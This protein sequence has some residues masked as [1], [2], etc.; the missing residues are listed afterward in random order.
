[1]ADYFED[2]L[3]NSVYAPD[4]D[5]DEDFYEPSKAKAKKVRACATART[6]PAGRV[7]TRLAHTLPATA[8]R[9]P[10]HPRPR[11][12]PPPRPP[13]RRRRPRPPSPRPPRPGPTR[14]RMAM[15]PPRYANASARRPL[16]STTHCSP[17]CPPRARSLP[18]L[19]RA[20]AQEGHA[21]AGRGDQPPAHRGRGGAC[22]LERHHRRPPHRGGLPEKVAARTHSAAPRHVHR[23]RRGDRAAALGL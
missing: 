5:S 7:L 4:D 20:Q 10:R 22:D 13:R 23:L 8:P 17:S 2:D 3:E 21:G 16:S 6:L 14:A 15:A 18:G 19:G 11:P 1:M 12:P 9:R